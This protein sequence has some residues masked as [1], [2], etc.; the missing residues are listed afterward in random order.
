MK[1]WKALV[2]LLV[3]LLA[4]CV[5]GMANGLADWQKQDT[6]NL[7]HQGPWQ[8]IQYGRSAIPYQ[9]SQ[10]KQT[11]QITQ[12]TTCAWCNYGQIREVQQVQRVQQPQCA[13]AGC[14]NW[15]AKPAPTM[16][17]IPVRIAPDCQQRNG[18]GADGFQ[19]YYDA[20]LANTLFE[21]AFVSVFG[22][23]ADDIPTAYG[24]NQ[25][26][27]ESPAV[28]Q[29]IVYSVNDMNDLKL[30]NIA[31]TACANRM[32]QTFAVAIAG[33]GPN[34]IADNNQI[35]DTQW[36]FIIDSSGNRYNLLFTRVGA[37]F[38][39]INPQT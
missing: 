34:V 23:I 19:L 13:P 25:V 14:G 10:E 38:W 33:S 18:I 3:C 8:E 5:S 28:I 35:L 16:S 24:T 20:G 4:L 31:A 7:G 39:M 12:K 9:P 21:A 6:V 37:E 29:S 30:R 32:G 17:T 22:Q 2:A 11:L 27:F 36:V 1:V 26:M 15:Q